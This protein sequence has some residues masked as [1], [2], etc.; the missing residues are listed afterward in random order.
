MLRAV[1]TTKTLAPRLHARVRGDIRS[2][3]LRSL[4]LPFGPGHEAHTAT[5]GRTNLRPL[6]SGVCSISVTSPITRTHG[7]INSGIT[8]IRSTLDNTYSVVTRHLDRATSIHRALERVFGAH[9]LIA[10]TAGGTANPSTV[11]C[12]SCFSCSR[13]L[14]HVTPRHLLTVLH[15]RSRN[16]VSIGVST[17]PRGYKGGVCCSFYRRHHC[18]SR[19]LTPC[20]RST[21]SSSFGELLRPSVSGRILGR[22]GRGTSVRSVEVFKRGLERL[23]L[24]TPMNRGEILTVS[25]NF[26]ANYGIIY[27]SRRNGLLRGRTVFPR[28]PTSRGIGSVRT[29]YAVIRHCNIR[30]VT[31][32]GKATKHRAR[33][34]V[35]HIPLPTKMEIFVIDRSKTSVCSTS[36]IT[37]T[38]FPRCSIAIHNTIS[39][40]HHLVSPLTRLIGVSPGSLKINRCRRSISRKLLGRALSGA[41]RDYIGG[42]NMGLG[43][44]DDC[45]LD[46][47]SKVNPTL[48]R[49]VIRC[50]SKRNTCTDHQSL[51]GIGQLNSGTFRRYT[52]F[53]H[54]RNTSGPLSG[55]TIRPRTCRVISHVTTSLKIAAKRLIKGT[56]L[57]SGVSTSS[58][59]SNSFNLPAVGSV[60]GRLHGPNHSPHR[61]TRRF[62]F[63]RSVGAVRSLGAN[64]RLPNVIAGVATFKTFISVKVGRGNLVRISRVNIGNRT[65]PSGILGLRRRIGIAILSM[66][67]SHDHVNLELRGWRNLGS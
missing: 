62:R 34:F 49:G 52:N 53:L 4:C 65:S 15:T 37:H 6:T 21:F 35:G 33:R 9:H 43:A 26:E 30:I 32:K 29:L 17:S 61:S 38:R 51:L 57:Y 23:L 19:T 50:H 47:I 28:P 5:T 27:L 11:G 31:V 36:S 60:L 24:T 16:F 46:C 63:T 2:H 14:R 48:T 39:V 54:V 20:V 10:E 44:T 55:S 25:P 42:I 45:L 3:R 12:G 66:S 56:S 59:I 41:I 58:C 22:T 8:S 7:C 13:S 64:V 18:P 40:N 1:S 67:L